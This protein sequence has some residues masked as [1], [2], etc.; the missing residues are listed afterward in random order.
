MAL[1]KQFFHLARPFWGG[2][3]QWREW[4]LLASVIGFTLFSILISVKIAAWDKHFYDA[5][6]A[7]NGKAMPALIVEYCGYMGLIIACIVCGDWLQKRLI[8]RWR[9]HLTER[10]QSDWL[11]GHKHY[12]LQLAGEPDNPDQRISDDIYQLADKSIV[13]FRSF[14]N[15]IAKFSAFVAVLWGLSGV[16]HFTL[17]GHSFTVKGYLV[18]VALAYSAVSTLIAHLVGRKL[19]DLNIDRQHR[20]ADFRAA[21]LRVRDHAEQVAF[22]QGADAEQGR[23]K[24]RYRQIRDNWRRLTNCEFRQETFWATYVRISIFIPILATLPMYLAKT[25]TFGDMMQTRTSFAR[26]QDS[27]GWFTDSYRR[28]VEWA[29]VVERLGG[30]QA[31]LDRVQRQPENACSHSQAVPSPACGGGLGWGQTPDTPADSV[32][33]ETAPP[34]QPSPAPAQEREQRADGIKGS[35]KSPMQPE[36]RP[37]LMLNQTTVH[38]PAGSMMLQAVSL[39]AT[40][41]EWLLL[42]G[43][44]GIGKSTLLR[45]LAGLW[46]Y[47]GGYFHI[48]GS[49]LFIPQRPYLPHGSLRDTIS[50]PHPCRLADDTLHD[51]LQH[52]GLGSLKN[53][54]DEAAEWHSRLSGGEQQRL[55]LARALA[56]RPQILFLDEATNQL[57]DESALALMRMLKTE[58]PDTLVVGISHQS[59]V[60]VLFDRRITLQ[61][62]KAA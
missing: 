15:N 13:L 48:N 3:N 28:L 26:V 7:F 8:F 46:P 5:L 53:R 2:K 12:R 51:I 37:V 21:L 54:L 6:A 61:R 39:E 42:E 41:P 57:D 36:N 27:F 38:T 17:F 43:R 4:L 10:F 31:A 20:E 29:A 47:H 30:F 14:I 34:P 23:L 22:Y 55:S 52:V 9:T 62:A 11:G 35:L 60:K 1:L 32:S 44:S 59:G 56:A 24:Q 49:F 33:A 50:Y 45:G 58:L 25:L 16:Q 18:W 40:A 19:K